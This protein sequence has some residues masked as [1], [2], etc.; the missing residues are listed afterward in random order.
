M[1]SRGPPEQYFYVLEP[2]RWCLHKVKK[3]CWYPLIKEGQW[4]HKIEHC[5]G[6]AML[7]NCSKKCAISNKAIN[8]HSRGPA[9]QF[10]C[11]LEPHCG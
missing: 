4:S 9:E 1:H 8:I 6:T 7:T 10:S 3:V 11:F 2:H 5:T